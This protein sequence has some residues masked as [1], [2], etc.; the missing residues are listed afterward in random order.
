MADDELRQ[1]TDPMPRHPGTV[2]DESVPTPGGRVVIPDEPTINPQP[3]RVKNAKPLGHGL[4]QGYVGAS[5]QD[6]PGDAEGFEALLLPMEF[7][8]EH[9]LTV[10]LF[11]SRVPQEVLAGA[12]TETLNGQF[13][14]FDGSSIA[15]EDPGEGLIRFDVVL[16][17]HDGLGPPLELTEVQGP[18]TVYLSR[19][20][21]GGLGVDPQAWLDEHGN[22][23][24]FPAEFLFGQSYLRFIVTSIDVEPT[25]LKL[26][27]TM[28][29]GHF[30]N[31]TVATGEPLAYTFTVPAGETL[32]N[33]A[34]FARV[35][36]EA[37]KAQEQQF[38]CD[39][40][41]GFQVWARRFEL[42]RVSRR[43]DVAQAYASGT[44]RVHAVVAVGP[45]AHPP[46]PPQLTNEPEE[47]PASADRELTIPAYARRLSLLTRY[48]AGG[49]PTDIPLGQIV[50][51]FANNRGT[52]ITWIDAI[53][54]REA[55]FGGDG[56]PIPAN[57]S[58]VVI[59]NKSPDPLDL[60]VL[61]HLG[62]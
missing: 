28:T 7:P 61:W 49:S 10:Q 53:S 14:R 24:P 15:D 41:N 48:G 44:V 9:L 58:A 38:D 21:E 8:T 3:P 55:L 27:V 56:L 47:V 59:T 46:F 45:A 20:G 13:W 42:W 29:S 5:F 52:A 6:R 60:G 31:P 39:W 33:A 19:T 32:A 11:D 34:V 26:H 16:P 40:C 17:E 12:S 51:G 54:A 23:I 30:E 2:P 43:A 57:A 37:G 25:Y 62:V 36:Y 50:V 22:P 1:R 18:A 4:S 35:R